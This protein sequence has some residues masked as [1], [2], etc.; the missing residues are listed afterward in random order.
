MFSAITN[1]IRGKIVFAVFILLTVSNLV[2]MFVTIN[3]VRSDYVDASKDN[4]AMLNA[5]IF[6]TLRT[7]MN[8][9]DPIQ[10]AHTEENAR[11][12]NG[13]KKLTVAKSKQLIDLYN[14]KE[15]FTNDNNVI[16]AFNTKQEQVLETSANG[17]S[18]IR[19]IK[20]MIATTECLACHTNQKEGDVIGV[21]DLT[22]SMDEFNA[23]L[24][25][26][27]VVIFLITT[28]LGWVSL[29]IIYIIVKKNTKPIED[30]KTGFWQLLSSGSNTNI[31]LDIHSNDEIGEVTTLFNDYMATLNKGL[32]ADQQF[33]EEVKTF[34]EYLKQGYFGILIS[35]SPNSQ[36]MIEL[37]SLL[38]ELSE[39]LN[40]AFKDMNKIMTDLSKGD[41]N[42]MYKKD[43]SG[44]FD[45]SKKAINSL[46]DELSSIL[47]G[48]NNAVDAAIKGN[49]KYRLNV[50]TYSGDMQNIAIGLNNVLE[51]FRV[52]LE[53]INSTM[54]QVS[55]G[56]L[57]IRIHHDYH[58]DYLQLKNSIN[59]TIS[60]IE[61][62][63][64]N[65]NE[66]SI[67]VANGLMD[68]TSTA[69]SISRASA[70]Q[71]TNLEETS[72]AVEEIA[73]N[74]NL[75]ANNAKHTAEMAQRASSIAVEGGEA[76]H[77][78]ADVMSDVANKIEQ[79]ED[80][81][82]QTNLLALNAAI[83]AARAGEHGKGFAV[84]AVE[85]RK[86]A[87]RS[88]QVASEIGAISKIS[89]IESRRAGDLI[90][91]IVPSTQST[92]TLVEEISSATEEQDI[93]IKQIHE[94]MTSLDKMTQDNARASEMLANNSKKMSIQAEK[95]T[96]MIRFFRVDKRKTGEY[97]EEVVYTREAPAQ[98]DQ[99]SQE[100]MP[101]A[102]THSS[103]VATKG[104][105]NV[106]SSNKDT[107]WVN[108]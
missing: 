102:P 17:S 90:N 34:S 62:V 85:V 2:V 23:K 47:M 80:I 49:F 107:N 77:R 81:A 91:E 45:I 54:S 11:K 31:H 74:I 12:I 25:S 100:R 93:G 53:D 57:T 9:G 35:S 97:R 76:V 39:G 21:I 69:E 19:M 46:S 104:I 42:A 43:V 58:G 29:G 73:G 6:Q 16:Q 22:F 86:L 3:Y 87:E 94:A 82:Y 26:L 83:E 89:V 72:V 66:I 41:F 84:V 98:Y 1:K 30:L 5:S 92:T 95:L 55:N 71:A 108:F 7:A 48:I 56:D 70:Q 60:K 37:K 67:A 51:G 63:I 40:G 28:I 13:V 10:I 50:E 65:A 96:D 59:S 36:S 61:N 27:L 4:I 75:S 68:V 105:K 15:N 38:N 20:P 32:Q 103:N 99:R 88:Q 33:I 8:S 79:I 14:A 101:S 78:T 44:E 106:E 24:N 18:E 64:A 52:A